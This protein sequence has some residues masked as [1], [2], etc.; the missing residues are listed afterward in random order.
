MSKALPKYCH[1]KATGQAYVKID[2]KRIYL[3]KHGSD[4][5][6]VAYT[7]ALSDWQ[8]RQTGTPKGLTVGQLCLLFIKHADDYY[9]QD[10]EPTGEANNFRKSITYLTALFRSLPVDEFGPKRLKEVRQSMIESGVVRTNI[11][12]HIARL[13]H[14]FKW[15]C[16]E[17]LVPP[18]VHQALTA[19]TGLREGRSDAV[20][21]DPVEPVPLEDFEK[22][23]NAMTD[24][25]AAICQLLLLTG[26]RVSEIRTMRVGDIDTSGSV[27]LYRPKSHKNSWRKK[28]RTIFIG[29]KGQAVLLPFI[30]DAVQSDLFVFRPF[31]LNEPYTL[32]GLGNSIRRACLKVGVAVW[33][34]G[35]LRHNAATI[36][37]Q[38]F[39]DIDGARVVL[40]HSEANTTKIYAEAD[41]RKAAEIIAKIG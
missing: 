38:E 5:S 24:N 4:A 18:A 34:P 16:S 8:S 6:R 37:N 9:Q 2:G 28:D 3:G 29:P 21:G 36:I 26:A 41:H 17:E 32:Q 33:S 27:W 22:A 25:V 15:G 19:I 20:E 35:R 13:K 39:G 1:H 12:R 14:V 40:G 7:Q 11:N 23:V 30:G 10:A 31:D